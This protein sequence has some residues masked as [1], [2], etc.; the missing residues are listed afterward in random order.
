[1][2][3]KSK[4]SNVTEGVI[5]KQVLVFFVPILIGAFFQ[6]FYTLVDTWIVGKY[7]G[8]VALAA[9]GGSASKIITMLINFFV[10]VSSGITAYAARH[11]GAQEY[12]RLEDAINNGIVLFAALGISFS[13]LAMFFAEE[14]LLRMATPAVTMDDATVYLRTFLAGLIFCIMFN[15]FSG[16]LR[17][18]GDSKRPLFVLMIC[19]VVN[20]ALDFIFILAL[21]WG[22]FGVA[23]ATCI[24]QALSAIILA[25][26]IFQS[27]NEA[28]LSHSQVNHCH[29]QGVVQLN[30]MKGILIIGLPAGLQSIMFSL[31]NIVVQSGVNTFDFETVAAWTAYVRIDSIVDMVLGALAGT[32]ITFVGQNYGAGNMLRVQRVVK[33][34]IIMSYI[35]VAA[36]M[37]VFMLFRYQL[38]GLFVEGEILEMAASFMFIVM[39]MYLLT[40]P[41][42]ML[43][44]A[45]RGLGQ[46]FVPM[47]LTMVGVVG[48]R[49]FWVK[50]LLPLNPTMHFMIACYPTSAVL[51]SVIFI[52]YYKFYLK[53]LIRK[54]EVGI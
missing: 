41:Q 19:S 27:M 20:I 32:V 13:A 34:I 1:M 12:H 7:L 25:F 40:I 39:P 51:M 10:G 38:L 31:S 33:E 44:N 49:I 43:S 35:V 18:L 3:K 50:I 14:I 16:I 36:L 23:L 42:Q 5:W 6:H 9:V 48:L 24:A 54:I 47:L 45:L 29:K 52:V 21:D 30:V 37:A 17:A 28:I 4:T 22:V 8:P 11:F 53:H 2:I 26:M 15:L 46:S